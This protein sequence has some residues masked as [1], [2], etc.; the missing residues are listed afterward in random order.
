MNKITQRND[1][2]S[3]KVFST[4][5][6][7][8]RKVFTFP[9]LCLFP[10]LFVRI[11]YCHR[12][13]IYMYNRQWCVFLLYV[14]FCF[15][16]FWISYD[17]KSIHVFLHYFSLFLCIDCA[18]YFQVKYIFLLY[19]LCIVSSILNVTKSLSSLSYCILHSQGKEKTMIPICGVC[20]TWDKHYV[21]NHCTTI[22]LPASF[23]KI[24]RSH[25][26]N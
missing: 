7:T 5:C 12:T 3:F 24:L 9:S 15:F 10:Y 16:A 18:F 21:A 17:I 25:W 1:W 23:E 13:T 20:G 8:F 14:N 26:R 19:F 2:N 11:N 22:I 4:I 6:L